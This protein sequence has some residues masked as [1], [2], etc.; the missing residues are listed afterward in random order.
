MFDG[1]LPAGIVG[2]A[3]SVAG[4]AQALLASP[5]ASGTVLDTDGGGL[6]V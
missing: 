1:A 2:D 5:Y 4:P 3:E 6:L